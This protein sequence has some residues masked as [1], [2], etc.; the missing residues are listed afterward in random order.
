MVENR[1]GPESFLQLRIIMTT[2][3]P[4]RLMEAICVGV[5][6][7]SAL[8]FLRQSGIEP[9]TMNWGLGLF[10]TRLDRYG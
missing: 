5:G 1:R 3:S 4:M 7:C 10:T 9:V 8:I 6:N 2:F